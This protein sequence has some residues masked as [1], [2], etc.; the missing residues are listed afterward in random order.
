MDYGWPK[1]VEFPVLEFFRQFNILMRPLEMLLLTLHNA[2][3]FFNQMSI[4]WV[5]FFNPF[6]EF[7]FSL[8]PL[9]WHSQV[10]ILK[11]FRELLGLAI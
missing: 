8:F 7:G 9:I 10:A 1:V 5:I 11:S 4:F 6:V 2:M 3:C